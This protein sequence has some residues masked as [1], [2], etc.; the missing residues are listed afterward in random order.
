MFTLWWLQPT[1]PVVT[2]HPLGLIQLWINPLVGEFDLMVDSSSPPPPTPPSCLASHGTAGV[3]NGK[4]YFQRWVGGP[5]WN[6][7]KKQ[8]KILVFWGGEDK[9]G[10]GE[11]WHS[12]HPRGTHQRTWISRLSRHGQQSPKATPTTYYTNHR[13]K[14]H[15][16]R[17]SFWIK[18]QFFF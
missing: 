5:V 9:P 14:C 18:M 6:I 2:V 12:S 8:R 3:G 11:A 15:L 10:R 17:F 13:S 7:L 16:F 1:P 4:G